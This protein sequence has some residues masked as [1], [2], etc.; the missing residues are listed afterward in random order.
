ML[1]RFDGKTCDPMGDPCQSIPFLKN[2]KGKGLQDCSWK[3]PM[4]EQFVKDCLSREGPYTGASK[5]HQEEIGAERKCYD[6]TATS[7][8]HHLA[9]LEG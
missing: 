4:M 3:A 7:I 9:L 2:C 5:E 8:P 6:L 1:E